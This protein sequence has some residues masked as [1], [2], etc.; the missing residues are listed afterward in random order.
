MDMNV[1][2][3]IKQGVDSV[4]APRPAPRSLNQ[5]HI[6]TTVQG[7][8]QK[9]IILVSPGPAG[10]TGAPAPALVCQTDPS[11]LELWSL[12]VSDIQKVV[13]AGGKTILLSPQARYEQPLH[14]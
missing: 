6:Q 14:K 8:V 2:A 9:P 12:S 5:T 4:T 11:L 13:T 3:P 10:M 1:S 7:P